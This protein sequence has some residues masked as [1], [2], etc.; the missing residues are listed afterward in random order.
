[1]EW[2][3]L[4]YIEVKNI[5]IHLQAITFSYCLIICLVSVDQVDLLVVSCLTHILLL[6]PLHN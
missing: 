4:L 1:M 6:N 2:Y 3:S 5:L